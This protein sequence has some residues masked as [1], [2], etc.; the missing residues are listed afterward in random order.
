[1][2]TSYKEENIK[3]ENDN[4]DYNTFN[5]VNQHY[6]LSICKKSES[7]NFKYICQSKTIKKPK[8]EQVNHNNRTRNNLDSLIHFTNLSN[9]NLNLV[10][11]NT[12]SKSE[13]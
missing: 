12:K 10:V 7:S 4:N 1:M 8:V 5:N 3:I 11:S 13:K 2:K 6:D 9:K